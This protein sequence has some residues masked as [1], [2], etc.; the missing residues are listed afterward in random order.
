ML[1]IEYLSKNGYAI[2]WDDTVFIIDYSEGR[3]PSQYLMEKKQTYFLVS[4]FDENHYD[5]SIKSYKKPIISPRDLLM[6]NA[7]VKVSAGDVLHF[8]GFRLI[9]VGHKNNGIA[10]LIE[11][12]GKSVFH[13]GNLSS[14]SKIKK[15]SNLQLLEAID[16][17]RMLIMSLKKVVR[18]NIMIA[19]VN[20]LW[21]E[22][23]D[24]DA[25]FMVETLKPSRFFPSNF[26]KYIADID[27]FS[28]WLENR[29][30]EFSGPKQENKK[31][32]IGE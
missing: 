6:E 10:Y 11:K 22:E 32:R 12:N 4:S 21:G 9:V 18:P 15:P 28:T 14:Q 2:E 31:Y 3:L 17:F 26:G 7:S 27:R 29:Q 24:E 25:K 19:S 5:E 23:Y 1:T 16:S 13:G 30:V 8:G 20:P